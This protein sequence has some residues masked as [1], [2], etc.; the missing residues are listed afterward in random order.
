M[1][2]PFPNQNMNNAG[3][4]GGFP[5]QPYGNMNQGNPQF[6]NQPFGNMN[7]GKPQLPNQ[8]ALNQPF[9]NMNQG[10]PQLPNQNA[11]NQ[12][13]GNMNQGNTQFP[14][15]QFS[16]NQQ[17]TNQQFPPNQQ[18]PNQQQYPPF[19]NQGIPNQGFNPGGMMN[20]NQQPPYLNPSNPMG[21]QMG[22]VPHNPSSVQQTNKVGFQ[23]NDSKMFDDFNLVMN[24]IIQQGKRISVDEIDILHDGMYVIGIKVEFKARDSNGNELELKQKHVGLNKNP[25]TFQQEHYKFSLGESITEIYGRAGSIIDQLY[26]R[27]SNGKYF[28]GGGNGGQPFSI[29]IP[30]GKSIVGF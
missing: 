26:I 6:P 12:P 9:G 29:I 22:F 18:F 4:Q 21:M 27:T 17:N 7:Q 13:F 24:G 28:G 30:P 25:T 14:N 10:N 11:L 23:Q 1:N 5:N 20:P 3:G 16:M 19:Q 2:Q 8:N 15:Q